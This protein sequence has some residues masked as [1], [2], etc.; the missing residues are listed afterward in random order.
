MFCVR[1]TWACPLLL[2]LYTADLVHSTTLFLRTRN[3]D[4]GF[5]LD[6]FPWDYHTELYQSSPLP[7]DKISSLKTVLGKKQIE[8][9]EGAFGYFFVEDCIKEKMPDCYLANPQT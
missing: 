1:G 3:T 8:V 5:K 4:P 6:H 7:D 9:S 2:L